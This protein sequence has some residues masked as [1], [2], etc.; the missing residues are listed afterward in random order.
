[1]TQV[2]T[3]QT[4][5]G[6]NTGRFVGHRVLRAEAELR[7]RRELHHPVVHVLRL[8]CFTSAAIF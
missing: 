1:V 6:A 5:A 2:Q 3:A 4:V 8:D 7:L